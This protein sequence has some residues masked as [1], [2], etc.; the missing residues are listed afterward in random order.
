MS[1]KYN[2]YCVFVP[3]AARHSV[4]RQSSNVSQTGVK[5]EFD[6][7]GSLT[8]K[9]VQKFTFY[10]EEEDEEEKRAKG[11]AYLKVCKGMSLCVAYAANIGGTGSV[12]GTSTNL[13]M[14]GQT[15]R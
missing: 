2:F 15:Q 12:S 13:I 11:E 10:D 9:T 5:V 6:P 8:K 1:R 3:L 14:L 7:Q 4:H